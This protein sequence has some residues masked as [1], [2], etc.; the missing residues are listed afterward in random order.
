MN[1]NLMY[2]MSKETYFE[3]PVF[4]LGA[5]KLESNSSCN[6]KLK[7]NIII[8]YLPSVRKVNTHVCFNICKY[9]LSGMLLYKI[10]YRGG[11]I[12]HSVCMFNL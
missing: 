11:H 2:F 12:C 6:W 7:Y 8:H 9:I 1:S 10:T 4:S 5:L 3:C